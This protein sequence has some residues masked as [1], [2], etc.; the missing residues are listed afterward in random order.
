MADVVSEVEL[1]FGASKAKGLPDQNDK[2]RQAAVKTV[3]ERFVAN[4]LLLAEAD[5]LGITLTPEDETNAVA[6]LQAMLPPGVTADQAMRQSP[7]GEARFREEMLATARIKKMLRT[8]SIPETSISDADYIAFTNQ[9]RT[10]I[11]KSEAVRARHILVA[12]KPTDDAA[13]KARKHEL[14]DSVR[15][16][17]LAG[18][19]FA[20]LAKTHS[21]C[22]SKDKGGDLGRFG[23]RKMVKPFSDAAFSQPVNAIGDVVETQFGYHVIQV[24]ERKAVGKDE[25]L[26][27]LR[28][29]RLLERLAKTADIRF[30]QSLEPRGDRR[31]APVTSAPLGTP[32]APT[33]PVQ[34][35]TAP[36][37]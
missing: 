9:F 30:N 34:G 3:V 21:D 13:E 32:Q 36:T 12:T 11:D 24:T 20:T 35:S 16:Q 6:S 17:L 5:R 29:R 18:A 28:R 4:T 2:V 31:E 7:V 37:P 1:V 8:A 25:L 19:D 10:E 26:D 22:P 27:I 14:A 33:P 15:T 23:R